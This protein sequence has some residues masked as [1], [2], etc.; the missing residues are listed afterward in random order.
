MHASDLMAQ[1]NCVSHQQGLC[2]LPV[3]A[4]TH[5]MHL[6]RALSASIALIDVTF[7]VF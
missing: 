4:V 2:V 5:R 6:S 1:P 7:D 3:P